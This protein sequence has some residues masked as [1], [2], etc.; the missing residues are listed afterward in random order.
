MH[1][2]LSKEVSL[3]ELTNYHHWGLS[4]NVNE[5]SQTFDYEKKISISEHKEGGGG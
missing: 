3:S 4:N 1:I 5:L 2:T